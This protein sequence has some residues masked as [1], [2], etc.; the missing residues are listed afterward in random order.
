[1]KMFNIP[2]LITASNML[3]G[4]FAI[5]LAFAG[6]IDI[7]PYF[8]FLAAVLDFFDGFLARIL[9]QQGELGKQL[10]SLADMIS[11]GL[12]PGIIMF[13]LMVIQHKGIDLFQS[14]ALLNMA[15][16]VELYDL[17]NLQWDNKL[18]FL[19]LIIPFFSLFRLAKFNIDTRQSESFIG[20]PTPANTIFFM[21]FPL[22]LSQYGGTTGWEHDL[23]LWLIQPIVL[24][25]VIVI[26]SV[27]L[28]SELPLFAL[29]FKHFKWK[30][31]GTRYVFL[32]SC[33]ILIS[34]L[35]IWSIPII[36]LLY[37]L[38]SFIQH[39]LRKKSNA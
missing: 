7:A 37:L 31:N 16:N 24:I 3:C 28:V 13:A 35:L 10:D 17:F 34:T 8:I 12:A 6:R 29:K 19:A 4:V 9:K 22:L 33:G 39:I 32:I 26:M 21:A 5:I 27:L 36:V 1:M 11:F 18:P 15:M 20:L 14:T 23:I 25:P 38:L 30:G 2:N